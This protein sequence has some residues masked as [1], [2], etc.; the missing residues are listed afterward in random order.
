MDKLSSTDA[1]LFSDAK[2][3]INRPHIIIRKIEVDRNNE[4]ESEVDTPVSNNIG[5]MSSQRSLTLSKMSSVQ[6]APAKD[7]VFGQ[8]KPGV[9]VKKVTKSVLFSN[10]SSPENRGKMFA[11]IDTFVASLNEGTNL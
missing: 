1:G 10:S 11:V 2:E 6:K 5:G 8:T 7:F 3:E 9:R 4:Y